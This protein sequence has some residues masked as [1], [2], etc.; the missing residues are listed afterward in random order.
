MVTAP[1]QVASLFT[2]PLLTEVW[3]ESATALPSVRTAI[4]DRQRQTEGVQLSNVLGW[5]SDD[6]M[7]EWGGDAARRLLA[8]VQARCDA[9]TRDL[10]GKRPRWISNMWANVSPPGASNQTHSH[11]GAYWSAVYYVEDGYGGSPDRALG[12]ELVFLDPRMPMVRART[13]D[14]RWRKPD[15]RYDSQEVWFRPTTGR[16]VMFPSWL[17]HSV[18]P[19]RGQ[20][21]RISIAM[22]FTPRFEAA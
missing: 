15:G 4:L 13:P 6:H 1:A 9:A 2:T 22:N 16:I 14:L 19:Y 3:A 8:H 5:Q 11:P 17:M 20:G 18:R 12:G 7:P 21:I 10:D